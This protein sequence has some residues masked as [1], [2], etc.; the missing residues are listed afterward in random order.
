MQELLGRA[1]RRRCDKSRKK[2]REKGR[3][4]VSSRSKRIL[5]EEAMPRTAFRLF[6]TLAAFLAPSI[7][8]AHPGHA[9]S[10]IVAGLLHPLSGLDHLLAMV[11]V[12]LLAA[13]LG[14]RALWAVP[15]A[16]VT[17]MALGGMA[18]AAGLSL[19]YVEVAVALS[20]AVFGLLIL[21]GKALP[22][23]AAMALVGAFAAFHGHAHGAEIPAHGAWLAYGLGFM[24]TTALLHGLGITL[25]LAIRWFDTAPR[26]HAMQACGAAIGLIGVGL[27]IGLA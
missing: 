16:F 8:L 22:V 13:E 21:S 20:V 10:G 26:R 3:V 11:A 12:G 2:T 9:E 1:G 27:L 6:V 24:A 14:G 4:A 25:G 5:K 15:A 23:G 7:A 17:I 19:P 18:G